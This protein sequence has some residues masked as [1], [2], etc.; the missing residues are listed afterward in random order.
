MRNTV[1]GHGILLVFLVTLF[2]VL[3]VLTPP[4]AVASQDVLLYLPLVFK[5]WPPVPAPPSLSPIDNADADGSYAV[6]WSSAPRAEDYELQEMRGTEGWFTAYLGTAT[7]ADLSNRPAGTYTYRCR[8]RNSWGEGSWSNEVSV[9]VQGTNPGS[10]SR[11]SCS[12]IDA[13][14]QSRAKVINDCPY[15]L[16][17]DFTGPQPLTMEL[18]KCDVCKVY[19]FMGPLFCPTSG[20]PVQEQSLAPGDYRVFVTVKDPGIRP[21]LGNWTLSGDC[22]YTTCFY[23]VT[24]WSMD[25][26]AQRQ[27]V[28]GRCD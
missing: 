2:C 21:Y 7:H 3:P 14:G 28:P 5:G 22:R 11:P 6:S 20:R 1:H 10:V 16:Y 13:G 15:Q 26:G 24:S 18:P 17:L 19:S 27:L 23:I 25:E 8:G 4:R 12:H 9:V